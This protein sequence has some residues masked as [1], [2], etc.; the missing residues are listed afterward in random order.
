MENRGLTVAR[1]SELR[2]EGRKEGA[3]EDTGFAS[4]FALLFSA[5]KIA[6]RN[7]YNVSF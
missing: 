3:I 6:K 5:V 7:K 4:I 2:K 1:K